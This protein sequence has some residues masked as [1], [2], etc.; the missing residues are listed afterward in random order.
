MNALRA[1][2]YLARADFLERARRYRFLIVLGAAVY[3]GYLVASG[4]FTVWLGSTHRGVYN[5]AWVGVLMTMTTL[6]FILFAGFYVVKNTLERDHRTGVGQIIA[7]TPVS[8][9]LYILGKVLSNLA[10][11]LAMIVILILAAVGAQL[12]RGEEAQIVVWPLLSPFLLIWLPAM[13]TV[14][15][16]AVLFETLPGLRGGW[17]NVV[18]FF[19]LM[20]LIGY[21]LILLF[22]RAIDV[23]FVDL[24]GYGLMRSVFAETLGSRIPGYDGHFQITMTRDPALQTILWAGIAWTPERLAARLYWFGVAF[25]LVL[26]ATVSFNRFDPARGL[27]QGIGL[28]FMVVWCRRVERWLDHLQAAAST[29]ASKAAGWLNAVL[30]RVGLVSVSGMLAHSRMGRTLLAELRLMLKGQPWWWY[31][32]ALGLIV[33]GST[34]D[35]VRQEVL[36]YAWLWPLL[37]WSAMGLREIRHGTDQL[38]FSAPHPLRHQLP[39][40]WLAGVV[41][42]LLAGSGVVVHLLLDG[43]WAGMS[44]LLVGAPFIPALALALGCWSGNSKLFE[45]VYTIL[46]YAGPVEGIAVLDFMGASGSSVSCTC[47]PVGATLSVNVPLIYLASTM[48]LLALALVGRKRQIT[49]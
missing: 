47:R 30:G 17:G 8:K 27:F 43:D 11:L 20:T 42:A 1:L 22:E 49:G 33:S 18:Y 31:L 24:M 14:A 15:A 45:V 48:V 21:H 34:G 3:L 29:I 12:A 26:A 4:R 35:E 5:S 41:V 40:T 44:A 36:P 23:P 25:V 28:T 9:R 32:V 38:V 16:L 6:F 13:A 19:L 2:Y 10:V 7:S 46:W 37:A 39:A